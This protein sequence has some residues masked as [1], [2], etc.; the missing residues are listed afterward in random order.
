MFKPN[1]PKWL[2]MTLRLHCLQP[3]RPQT[4]RRACRVTVHSVG[5]T[6]QP[7][8][9][10]HPLLCRLCPLPLPGL[11]RIPRTRMIM[12]LSIAPRACLVT[13]DPPPAMAPSP[14]LQAKCPLTAS[15]VHTRAAATGQ[16]V[17]ARTATTWTPNVERTEHASPRLPRRRLRPRQ[18]SLLARPSDSI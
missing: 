6:S 7:C 10:L 18:P 13:T 2:Q 3:L 14:P 8:Q 11:F 16:T 5:L 9:P 15:P 1:F 17:S 12:T 4:R